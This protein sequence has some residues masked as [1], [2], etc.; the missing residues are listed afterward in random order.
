MSPADSA[1]N[2]VHFLSKKS[3]RLLRDTFFF[4]PYFPGRLLGGELALGLELCTVHVDVFQGLINVL[5]Q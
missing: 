1:D 3:R 2:T 5:P 4:L